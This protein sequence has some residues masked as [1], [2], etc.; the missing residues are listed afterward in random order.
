M[1][2]NS[3][4]EKLQ[5]TSTNLENVVM[6]FSSLETFLTTLHEEKEFKNFEME[7]IKMCGPNVYKKDLKRKNKR[8]IMFDESIENN[9]EFDG[10][11]SF[12]VEKYYIAIDI[13]KANLERRRKIYAEFSNQFGF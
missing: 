1:K 4:S 5:K 10:R 6:L 8:K 7:P 11:Q 13:L 3:I 2:F 12:I 9:T